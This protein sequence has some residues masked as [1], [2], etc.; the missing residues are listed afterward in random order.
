MCCLCPTDKI[1]VFSLPSGSIW[2]P[3]RFTQG[4]VCCWKT[5]CIYQATMNVNLGGKLRIPSCMNFHTL[6][7]EP[8]FALTRSLSLI[9]KRGE[10]KLQDVKGNWASNKLILQILSLKHYL[11]SPEVL[12]ML[13]DLDIQINRYIL[14]YWQISPSKKLSGQLEEIKSPLRWQS[15]H[16]ESRSWGWMT[17]ND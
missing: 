8:T 15:D 11:P 4:N 9:S 14:K 6:R 10:R 3:S 16:L 7:R 17:K 12:S 2:K 13:K 5:G 1:Q